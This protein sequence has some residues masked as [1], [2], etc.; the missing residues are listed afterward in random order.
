M[1]S[2]GAW[3]TVTV[4]T[5]DRQLSL[6]LDGC[7]S[8]V[9]NQCAATLSLNSVLDVVSSDLIVGGIPEIDVIENGKVYIKS[10]FYIS[11]SLL[12]LRSR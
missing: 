6:I 10:L 3:H 7:T 8:V 5:A 1:V 11:F 4:H 2:D 12:Y 9:D